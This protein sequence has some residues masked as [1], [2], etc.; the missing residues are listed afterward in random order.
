M[1]KKLVLFLLIIACMGTIFW[2]SAQEA[3]D[4]GRASEGFTYAVIKFFDFNNRI[5]NERALEIAIAINGIVRKVAH[6]GIYALLAFLISLLINE[7]S[8]PYKSI[9]FYSTVTSFLYSCT[10]E[11]HQYF[12]PGR[13]AQVSDIL[14]D[15][16]GAICGA[17]FAIAIIVLIISSFYVP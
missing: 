6:F 8:F 12:V 16:F 1:I 17:L 14:L 13:S 15:S 9:V 5:S 7:Y 4:S 2:F 10:D 3:D 11:V